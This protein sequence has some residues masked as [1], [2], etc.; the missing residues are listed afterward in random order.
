[1]TNELD[2]AAS[3][4]TPTQPDNFNHLKTKVVVAPGRSIDA[5]IGWQVESFDAAGN[6]IKREKF[7]K[8]GPGEEVELPTDEAVRLRASGYV[9]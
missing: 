7:K 3:A 2:T 4:A 5:S 6:P 1:M 9:I 8:F